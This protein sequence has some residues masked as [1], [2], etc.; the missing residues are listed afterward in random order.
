M[1]VG[2][3]AGR[4]SSCAAGVT[5]QTREREREREERGER[6]RGRRVQGEVT[7]GHCSCAAAGSQQQGDSVTRS[8]FGYYPASWTHRGNFRVLLG[9]I[10]ES[11][12]AFRA[13]S[14]RFYV[15][16]IE[17][18]RSGASPPTGHCYFSA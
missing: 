9:S 16:G 14:Y 1:T 5:H 6:E 11:G 2:A 13:G 7:T 17:P 3:R 15:K 10:D 12:A 18:E 8:T 4:W